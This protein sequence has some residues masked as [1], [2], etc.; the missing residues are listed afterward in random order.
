[1]DEFELQLRRE[2]AEQRRRTVRIMAAL[3]TLALISTT[4]AVYFTGA[5]QGTALDPHPCDPAQVEVLASD[6]WVLETVKV[7][8]AVLTGLER[9]PESPEGPW[10]LYFGGNVDHSLR[11]ARAYF[12]LLLGSRRDY[13]AA[14]FA[15]RGFD[16]STG[17]TKPSLLK[18]DAR[19]VFDHLVAKHGVRA[20]R[21]HVIGFSLG[22]NAASLLGAELAGTEHVLASTTLLS[23]GIAPHRLPPWLYPLV[24]GAFE[25]PS[26]LKAMRGPVLL[27][28]ARDDLAY[29]PHIH[30]RKMPALLGE[31]LVQHIEVSGGHDGPLRDELSLSAIRAL[32]ALEPKAAPDKTSKR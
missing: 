23:P 19:T 31:R 28:S 3:A 7:D 17:E 12:E 26:K 22:A 24:L 9:P 1:M 4:S 11:T 27:V 21:L 16:T 20:E 13:G 29:P 8:G 14:S 5:Y 2:R 10:V 15:Y 25:M 30:A 32:I 6:G 18:A